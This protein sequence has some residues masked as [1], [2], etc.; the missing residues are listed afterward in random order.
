MQGPFNLLYT[1]TATGS[2]ALSFKSAGS[3][4]PLA[5]V[6]V[7]PGA[8]TPAIPGEQFTFPAV[9]TTGPISPASDPSLCFTAAGGSPI[10]NNTSLQPCGSFDAATATQTFVVNSQGY[11][12]LVG[13]G[14]WVIAYDSSAIVGQTLGIINS[15]ASQLDLAK[16]TPVV[17]EDAPTATVSF[18]AAV[19]DLATIS[20]TG[21]EGATITVSVNGT[22]IGSPVVVSGGSWSLPIPASIGAGSHTFTV[23]QTLNGAAA[24]STTATADFG[25]AVDA[26]GPTAEFSGPSTAVTGT[27]APGATVI[28]KEGGATIGTAT[29][30]ANGTWSIEATGLQD[31]AHTFTATQ[32]A[33]GNVV[34]TDTL[35]VTR[36]ATRV[37]VTQTN[38]FDGST[39]RP[40]TNTFTGTGT[41]GATITLAVTNFASGS[42]TT[43]VKADGTWSV[44]RNLGSGTYVFTITQDAKGSS[45]SISDITLRPEGSGVKR[46]FTT[47]TRDGDTYRMGTVT[48]TGTGDG[49][50]TATVT[51][52][53]VSPSGLASVTVPVDPDGTWTLRRS[54]GSGPYTVTFTQTE[55]DGSTEV[56]G[57]YTLTPSS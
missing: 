18:G 42:V 56:L 32:T 52:K 30:A 5:N 47:V 35:T 57:P 26:T 11:I 55:G 10:V 6:S 41:P 14:G 25:A 8:T 37:N 34:T 22:P 16:M 45:D 1:Y 49:T 46:P 3:G 48:F 38:L 13:A 24:G 31:G 33:R 27:G 23:T 44:D 28:L 50:N 54:M 4:K 21:A 9:G 20:G 29:V 17:D 36:N 19:T 15:S 7:T 53:V 51:L 2:T 12:N 39:F 40:G 43:T